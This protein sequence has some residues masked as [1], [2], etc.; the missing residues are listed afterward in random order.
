MLFQ[1]IQQTRC[2]RT[3]GQAVDDDADHAVI[4]LE[5]R[6]NL[7]G[8]NPLRETLT[9]CL[10]LIMRCIDRAE[11]RNLRPPIRALHHMIPQIDERTAHE[12][13]YEDND[14]CQFPITHPILHACSKAPVLI[15]L[16]CCLFL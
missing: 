15:P 11:I 1:N 7:S 3:L 9:G 8:L 6:H 5:T 12:Q 4:P 10:D 16:C 2:K 13:E 14:Q